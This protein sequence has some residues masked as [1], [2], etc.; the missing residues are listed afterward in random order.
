MDSVKLE[1]ARKY[2][3]I[4]LSLSIF[5]TVLSLTI[6]LLFV[7][8]GYSVQLRDL[9]YGWFENPYLRLISF[10]FVIGR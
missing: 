9:V 10:L 7:V 5:S 3:K 2:E 6:F 8:L 1:K 4:N